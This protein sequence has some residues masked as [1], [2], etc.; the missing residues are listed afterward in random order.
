[1]AQSCEDES[2][3]WRRSSPYKGGWGAETTQ[4]SCP[5]M[6][7]PLL[8][9]MVCYKYLID[10]ILLQK[11]VRLSKSSSYAKSGG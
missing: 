5:W 1:M 10:F 2:Y 4:G 6:K 3:V 8:R 7:L 11:T 9:K